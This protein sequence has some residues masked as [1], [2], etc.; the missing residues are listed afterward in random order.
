M[1]YKDYAPTP[2]DPKGLNLHDQQD[3]IVLPC[4]QNRDSGPLQKSNFECLLKD[5]GGESE[6]VEVHRFGHWACG[7]FEIIIVHPSLAEK[8]EDWEEALNNYPVVDEED[9]C[10]NIESGREFDC[11]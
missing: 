9:Y 1:L 7:W 2:C 11:A 10:R 3:W 6:T 4:G 8:V 5:F